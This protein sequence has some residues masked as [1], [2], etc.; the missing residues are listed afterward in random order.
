LDHYQII[1]VF[2]IIF[3]ILEIF[4][5]LFVSG[6][7]AIGLLFSSLASYFDFSFKWQIYLF[8]IGLLISFFGIRIFLKRWDAKNTRKTN[9]AG[10]I[11]KKAVVVEEI[12]INSIGR[13]KIDG[14]IWQA[15]SI[16]GKDIKEGSLT[17]IESHDSIVLIV[18]KLN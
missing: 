10:L 6:S 3:F 14:D 5:G 9:N 12:K 1:I 17:N 8:A 2:A 16:D 11:G 18:K 7:I 4:T 13:V 15:K